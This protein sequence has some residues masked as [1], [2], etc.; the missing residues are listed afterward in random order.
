MA[1]KKEGLNFEAS[2][3]KL[4]TIVR[5]LEDEEAPLEES[6]KL[7]AEGKQLARLCEAELQEAE[8]RVRQLIEND[9]GEVVEKEFTAENGGATEE[10]AEEEPADEPPAGDPAPDRPKKSDEARGAAGTMDDLPF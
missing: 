3:K 8:N 2:L 9:K 7:F 10:S 4:E 5:R 1:K 6:L